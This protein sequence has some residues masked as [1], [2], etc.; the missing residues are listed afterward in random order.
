M[1]FVSKIKKRYRK[2]RKTRLCQ[3]DILRDLSFSIKDLK[4]GSNQ[5]NIDLS[6]A[7]VLSQECDIEQDFDA[8]KNEGDNDKFLPVIL[9]CPAYLA[10]PFC[11]GEHIAGW[12]MQNLNIGD[13]RKN[14]K[15]KRYHYLYSD[16]DLS[17]PELVIDFKH[18]F[19]LPRNLLYDYRRVLYV[20]TINELFREELSQRFSNYLSRIGLPQI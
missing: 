17:I 13:L 4:Y 5:K 20:A 12:E 15:L 1:P 10:S 7:V 3:G 9:V 11:N 19:T 8:R 16:V 6:F 2:A 18:F 14:D